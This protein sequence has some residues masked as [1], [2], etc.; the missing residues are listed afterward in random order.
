MSIF[1][2]KQKLFLKKLYSGKKSFAL[3]FRRKKNLFAF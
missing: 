1:E 2:K 3:D